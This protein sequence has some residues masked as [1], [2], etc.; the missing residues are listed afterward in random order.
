M[1][2]LEQTVKGVIMSKRTLC[3]S[4]I[5]LLTFFGLFGTTDSYGYFAFMPDLADDIIDVH[6]LPEQPTVVDDITI[7][8]SGLT[9]NS[10]VLSQYSEF[11][12][13]D[14]SLQLDIFIETGPWTSIDTWWHSEEIGRLS[15]GRYDLAVYAFEWMKPAG[16]HIIEFEVVPEP[17]SIFLL[18]IGIIGIQANKCNKSR[19]L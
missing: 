12:V 11:S 14:R 8:A 6:I 1:E 4:A 5:I 10:P 19:R 3:L 13:L 17:A 18:A 9:A 7:F 15:V 16:S 2:H